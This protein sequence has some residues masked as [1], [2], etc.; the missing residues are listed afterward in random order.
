[1]ERTEVL[2]VGGGPTGL[3]LAGDLA[4]AG[5]SVV[6]AERWPSRNPSSR[7]FATMPRTVE[8]FESRGLA[9]RLVAV[10][11]KASRVNLWPG[12]AVRLDLL[13]T[14]HPYVVVTPQTNV[15]EILEDYA[16]EQ[17]ARIQRGV[18]VVAL[19]QDADGATVVTRP[20]DGGAEVR[21]R[22]DYVVGADGA[23]STV[24]TLLGVGFPGRQVLSSVVLADVLPAHPPA[25]EGL[26]LGSTRECFGFL[27]PYGNGWYRSMTWDRAKQLPDDAPAEDAD[28]R[29]VLDRAMER[30][31]GVEEIGWRS[32]FSCAERQVE[33]YRHGRVFLA[34]DAA[35]VHSPM[36]GQGMNTG[37]QDAVNLAWKLAAVLTGAPDEVLDTY[38]AERHPIGRRVL[39]Q[40]GAMMR[41]V[42][43]HPRPARR[44][45]TIVG[46][47]LLN[48]RPFA[49]LVAGS[50]SG[51][52]LRYG[53][54]GPVGT[55]ATQI[56]LVEGTV[57]KQL[58]TLG[59]LLIREQGAAA[60]DVELAQ[61]ERADAG[62]AVLVRPD[63]YVAWAGPRV[64]DDGWRS[65]YARWTGLAPDRSAVHADLQLG[66]DRKDGTVR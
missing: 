2:V 5:R 46:T 36:G 8:L 28:I 38:H 9:G 16:R 52:G 35:H 21:W 41:A 33:R 59:F 15:D 20:K 58:G 12:A 54:R 1:M 49:S 13:D 53:R 10:G 32:R 37:I 65:A 29:E 14:P 51:V 26:T 44:M 7:A 40:S 55:R 63:G 43:L 42:T 6:V 34:G 27:A 62:P 61:A 24:R 57:L 60:V 45:R 19:G 11:A 22:A 50:F 48:W 64:V 25:E 17:G 30:A 56:P 39:V 3:I 31:V 18:E 23:H 4:R 47:R 66:E